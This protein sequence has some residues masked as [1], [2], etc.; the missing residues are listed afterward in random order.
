M[1]A[2]PTLDAGV[3]TLA[4]EI[5]RSPRGG[6]EATKNIVAAIR[7]GGAGREAEGYAAALRTSPAARERIREFASRKKR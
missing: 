6:L 2:P 1:V 7:A 4:A 5:A 3:A